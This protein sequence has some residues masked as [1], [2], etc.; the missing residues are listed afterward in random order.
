MTDTDLLGIKDRLK[1]Y[2]P[3]TK[4]TDAYFRW[5]HVGNDLRLCIYPKD[6]YPNGDLNAVLYLRFDSPGGDK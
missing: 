1:Q 4:M 6:Q 5:E 3:K 2:Y